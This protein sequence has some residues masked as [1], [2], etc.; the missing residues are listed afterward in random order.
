MKYRSR[1][2]AFSA[3][4]AHPIRA[5]ATSTVLSMVQTSGDVGAGGVDVNGIERLAGGHEQPVA[6]HAA[7]T[8]VGAV[9]GEANHPDALAS[10]GDHLHSGPCARPDVAI[11]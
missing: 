9:L 2:C 6:L 4:V 8:H 3:P 10:R 7:E 1:V 11:H 5:A